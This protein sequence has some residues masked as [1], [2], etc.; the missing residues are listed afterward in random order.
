VNGFASTAEVLLSRPLAQVTPADGTGRDK[1]LV[2]TGSIR[3][4]QRIRLHCKQERPLGSADNK[5][6]KLV[7]VIGWVRVCKFRLC[8]LGILEGTSPCLMPQVAALIDGPS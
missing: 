8:R 5:P 4:V 3:S 1:T 6:A 2:A 7:I